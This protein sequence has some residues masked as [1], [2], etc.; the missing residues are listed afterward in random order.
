MTSS[1]EAGS[2]IPEVVEGLLF[3]EVAAV[4]IVEVNR[5]DEEVLARAAILEL[6]VETFFKPPCFRF[7]ARL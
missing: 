4:P 1:S 6:R 3:A 7:A 2:G 5:G